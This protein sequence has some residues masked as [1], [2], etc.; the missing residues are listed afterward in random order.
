M[1]AEALRELLEQVDL[2]K[3]SA[4]IKKELQNASEQKRVKLI[5]RL[6]TVEAFQET[7]LNGWL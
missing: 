4:Q 2:E 3:L 7:D 6:D 1:G 5:K